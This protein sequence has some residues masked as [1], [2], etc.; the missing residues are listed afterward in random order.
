MLT[1]TPSATIL[2]DAQAFAANV[3]F[4]LSWHPRHR[5]Q[6]MNWQGGILKARAG[7]APP[8]APARF[9]ILHRVHGL[10]SRLALALLQA[11]LQSLALQS[12]CG[13]ADCLSDAFGL[14]M[15]C[16]GRFGRMSLHKLAMFTSMAPEA[17]A[18]LVQEGAPKLYCAC[19]SNGEG[20]EMVECSSGAGG[21]GLL[22]SVGAAWER[23]HHSLHTAL[24]LLPFVCDVCACV[25]WQAIGCTQC[26]ASRTNR[27]TR[28][29]WMRTSTSV[30]FAA[31]ERITFSTCGRNC[32]GRRRLSL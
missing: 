2:G 26:A 1:W 21:C 9:A 19:R 5:H 20:G 10:L 14:Q 31:R 27:S 29:R 24:S 22:V 11:L 25:H 17:A 16:T 3:C 8:T 32:G 23:P 13:S 30:C 28:Q 6:L 15:C 4:H 18:Q 7:V 12:R